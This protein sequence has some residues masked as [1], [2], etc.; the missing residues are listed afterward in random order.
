MTKRA[1]EHILL[2]KRYQYP[3][4]GYRAKHISEVLQKIITEEKRIESLPYTSDYKKVSRTA[5]NLS[6][7]SRVVSKPILMRIDPE[8]PR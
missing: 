2:E 5:K 3:K 8:T 4:M 7:S 6:T 1:L